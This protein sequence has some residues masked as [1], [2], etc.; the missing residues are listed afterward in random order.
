MENITIIV[1]DFTFLFLAIKFS[2]S[3]NPKI[4]EKSSSFA[5]I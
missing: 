1:A 4:F 3:I 5:L 2:E